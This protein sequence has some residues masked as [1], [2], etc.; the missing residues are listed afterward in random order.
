MF[1]GNPIRC[2]CQIRPLVHFYRTV[3]NLPSKFTDILC[4]S[5]DAVSGKP[6][7]QVLDDNLNCIN[8]TAQ[9]SDEL[10]LQPDLKIREIF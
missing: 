2:D 6:L 10:D 5:P 8:E 7:Y 9:M 4:D 3:L 1:L